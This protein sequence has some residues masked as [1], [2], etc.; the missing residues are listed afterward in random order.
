MGLRLAFS[1]LRKRLVKEV[2]QTSEYEAETLF[3]KERERGK[4]EECLHL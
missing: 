3:W 2:V 1:E 4:T